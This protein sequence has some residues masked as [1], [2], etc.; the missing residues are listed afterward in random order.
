MKT[1]EVTVSDNGEL[2]NIS[3]ISNLQIN[4][5]RI[6]YIS[7]LSLVK[8][9]GSYYVTIELSNREEYSYYISGENEKAEE[10]AKELYNTLRGILADYVQR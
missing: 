5:F 4:T 3:A 10:E 1:L 7:V 8:M 6:K 2:L 9:G